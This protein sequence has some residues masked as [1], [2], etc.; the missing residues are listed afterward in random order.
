MG[1]NQGRRVFS[2]GMKTIFGA[3][4]KVCFPSERVHVSLL[5]Y[6]W[7]LRK[8]TIGYVRSI[9]RIFNS[10]TINPCRSLLI[11]ILGWSTR[12]LQLFPSLTNVTVASSLFNHSNLLW[13]NQTSTAAT[14]CTPR[15]PLMIM[16]IPV[17]QFRG[18]H[19]HCEV[20]TQLECI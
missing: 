11:W 9:N 19:T 20:Q 6:D 3:K 16:I 1:E 5:L 14:I 8:R 7:W 2:R 4:V 10:W 12:T 17:F 13:P 15:P 18:N